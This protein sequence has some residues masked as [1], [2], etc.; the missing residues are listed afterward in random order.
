MKNILIV[1]DM[2]NGFNRYEQTQVLGNKIVEL[3]ES[4]Y[5][6]YI[7]ATRFINFEG[8]QYTK[9]LNWH[10][11]I[12]SPDIDLIKNLQ[13]DKIVDKN[14]Y[15]CINENFKDLLKSINNNKL[16]T[17]IFICGADTDCCVLKTAT[18]LFEIGIMPL[19]LLNY[20]DSNGGP[21]SNKAGQLVMS[22]LIGKNALI[23]EDI[24]CKKQLNNLIKAREF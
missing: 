24:N 7:I 1:V 21:E 17:H 16:P 10:R 11:L 18:D 8:S 4:G 19:V 20:C 12:S 15:T 3:T 5:F 6:D 23:Y 2:Q 22:R 9:I 14:I 13:A